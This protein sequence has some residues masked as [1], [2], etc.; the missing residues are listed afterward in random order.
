MKTPYQRS[1]SMPVVPANS[2]PWMQQHPQQQPATPQ[3]FHDHFFIGDLMRNLTPGGG[4]GPH[5][6]GPV[7]QLKPPDG[8]D[9]PGLYNPYNPMMDRM[10]M[11]IKR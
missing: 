9:M 3:P 11:D 1:S 7:G 2:W 10:D 5:S 6:G 4:G 8:I